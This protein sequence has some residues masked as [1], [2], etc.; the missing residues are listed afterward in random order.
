MLETGLKPANASVADL[1]ISDGKAHW[2][3]PPDKLTQY[4]LKAGQAMSTSTG[5]MAVDT[6]EFKGRSPKDRFIVK[7]EVT[8]TS[9]WW[10]NFNIPIT[11]DKFD[12]LYIKMIRYFEGKEFFVRD[13]F[14]CADWRYRLNIR[15]INEY[16]WSNLFVHNMFI[17]PSEKELLNFSAEWL[18]LNAPGFRANPAEDGTRQHNFSIIDFKRKII[19]IGG[20][21]YTGEIKKA[22]FTAL[23]FIL[24]H[25][26][27][28]LSM[29]CSANIG[30]K[31]DT[32]LFFGLS[33]TG[34]T[35]LSADPNRKLI[36]DDEHGWTTDNVIF[37]FEGGCYAKTIELSA[38]KE[39]EIF[40][41]I[42]DGAL[43]ENI[44][45]Y[46]GSNVVNYNDSRLTENTRVSYPLEHIENCATP[47]IGMNPKNIFFLACDAFGV[48]P[49]IAKLTPGQAAF[50][51]ISGYTAR[52]AGTEA[53]VIEPT[54]TFS[55]C[56]GAPFMPLHP[57]FYAE[58][59]SKKIREAEV[60]VWL[61]NTGWSG[62]PYGVGKRLSLKY[63][64]ALIAA[65]LNGSLD[66]IQYE[67]HDVF[68]VAVP[69]TCMGVP[70]E[71]LNPI[72]TWANK[73]AYELKAQHLANSFIKNFEVFSSY[74]N[75]EILAGAP[76][77]NEPA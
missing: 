5:A 26:K 55:A 49:P 65:A 68:G 46:E 40:N 42:R 41:A 54:M 38:E 2:N 77:A 12:Q 8:S 4:T 16:A 31:S 33:G 60:N 73:E 21:G 25:Y 23:N 63:T 53:D 3:M 56:F 39:P 34:K 6:G 62:G 27:S 13:V 75:A 72:N 32:A 50:H 22:V 11:A 14:A 18:I 20:S 52:V 45:F 17:R 44:G 66:K 7:D 24:P 58:M 51:F 57:T 37:N 28:V 19:L 30:D 48:L 9:V 29:H 15:V 74:A 67:N 70:S 43:L 36:G 71:I 1:G 10:N 47:S 76:H 35:T 64:R 59:L 61:V 69:K